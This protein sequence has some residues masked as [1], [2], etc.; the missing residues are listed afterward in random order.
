[1]SFMEDLP[2]FLHPR[3]PAPVQP[4]YNGWK[5]CLLMALSWVPNYWD[6]DTSS[7]CRTFIHHC[8]SELVSMQ[9]DSQSERGRRGTRGPPSRDARSG[10]SVKK[11]RQWGHVYYLAS[12]ALWCF[13]FCTTSADS[14]LTLFTVLLSKALRQKYFLLMCFWEGFRWNYSL[15]CYSALF[16]RRHSSFL[17]WGIWGQMA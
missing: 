7:L 14:E 2:P 8:N 4:L 12:N 15:G 3:P 11:R 17:L 9:A 6:L 5:L 1:M 16:L 13:I 10:W